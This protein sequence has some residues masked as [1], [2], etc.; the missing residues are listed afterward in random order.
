MN[1]QEVPGA[2]LTVKDGVRELS[3]DASQNNVTI[4]FSG[5]TFTDP[6][7]MAYEYQMEGVD[8]DWRVL[9]GKSEVTYYDLSSDNYLFKVR[10]MGNPKSETCLRIHMQISVNWYGYGITLAVII[11]AALSAYY[12]WK[13]KL[14]N[15]ETAR[16]CVCLKNSGYPV[17]GWRTLI[18]QWRKNTKPV[19]SPKKNV[20]V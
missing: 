6:A 18:Y 2:G 7:Y 16:F 19:I 1:G 12:L 17:R 14:Q 11:L 9:T 4:Y 10:R 13:R 15:K 5:F 20:S 3:L 8:K